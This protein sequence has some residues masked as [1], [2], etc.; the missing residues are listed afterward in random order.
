MKIKNKSL[1]RIA[2]LFNMLEDAHDFEF[3]FDIIKGNLDKE[4]E[5]LKNK[6]FNK[7]IDQNKNY[8]SILDLRFENYKNRIEDFT[9]AI[10]ND[11]Y[12][13]P[14]ESLKN[15]DIIN[16]KDIIDSW[17]QDYKLIEVFLK[18]QGFYKSS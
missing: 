4:L 11:E 5:E 9:E 17:K 12:Y 6:D 10:F 18:E 13:N 14:L 15:M 16:S 3:K 1:S 2:D 8:E 7:F